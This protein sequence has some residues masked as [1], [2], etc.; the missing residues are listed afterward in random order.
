MP[1]RQQEMVGCFCSMT[2]TKQFL[3]INFFSSIF[4]T[5]NSFIAQEWTQCV[6]TPHAG[7][8]EMID[9]DNLLNTRCGVTSIK[10]TGRLTRD[11]SGEHECWVLSDRM[12][13]VLARAR[14]PVCV[15]VWYEDTITIPLMHKSNVFAYSHLWVSLSAVYSLAR[16]VHSL[17]CTALLQ[18]AT[19]CFVC[20]CVEY[21]CSWKSGSGQSARISCKFLHSAQNYFNFSKAFSFEY[22]FANRSWV[23]AIAFV[24]LLLKTNKVNTTFW[25]V[26]Q[27]NAK[28]STKIG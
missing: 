3:F 4:F 11:H 5:S 12:I 23:V 8:S 7:E 1:E 26:A 20:I 2:I 21:S 9:N 25:R 10:A 16:F 24:L 27:N 28:R 18:Y 17:H 15:C 22:A 6:F 14:M 19:T 13:G